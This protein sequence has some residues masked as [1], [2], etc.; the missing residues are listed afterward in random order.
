MRMLI[1]VRR[2]QLGGLPFA[3]GLVVLGNRLHDGLDRQARLLDGLLDRLARGHLEAELLEARERVRE[4]VVVRVGVLTDEQVAHVVL[5]QAGDA[6][7]LLDLAE[8]LLHEAP[9]VRVD[10]DAVARMHERRRVAVTHGRNRTRIELVHV[11]HPGHDLFGHAD[12]FT[13]RPGRAAHNHAGGPRADVLADH[14][15]V[16]GKA[17]G[18]E[19]HAAFGHQFD[20]AV[21]FNAGD[22][23]HV[24]ALVGHELDRLRVVANGHARLL[25]RLEHHLHHVGAA[26]EAVDC[27]HDVAA[28]AF[29]RVLLPDLVRHAVVA[30]PVDAFARN[31]GIGADEGRI[32]T[33]A[34]NLH[35]LLEVEFLGIV[36]LVLIARFRRGDPAGAVGGRAVGT[37]HL[38]DEKNLGALFLGFER[39]AEAREA[40]AH[41]DDVPLL[42][43]DLRLGLD[44]GGGRERDACGSGGT[45]AHEAGLEQIAACSLHDFSPFVLS[46][47]GPVTSDVLFMLRRNT[48]AH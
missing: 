17:A 45:R 38:L 15:V 10:L 32:G 16:A 5:R 33:T 42:A 43:G 9:A 2:H 34:R 3:H 29:G 21:L 12:V 8:V 46:G 13:G 37:A 19:N 26:R 23:E 47:A 27:R 41:H 40:R 4:D 11:H 14:G 48:S 36:V 7:G 35:H 30:E 6:H 22:A 28:H 1:E 20:A 31:L 44:C 39:G 18:G 25:K 24:E